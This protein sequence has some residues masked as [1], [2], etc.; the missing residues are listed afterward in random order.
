MFHLVQ[1]VELV[2]V[3]AL[4]CIQRPVCVCVCW[5]LVIML[6]AWTGCRPGQCEVTVSCNTV[7]KKLGGL[8]IKSATGNVAVT[9]Q[10]EII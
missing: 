7:T 5:N 9:T 4:A 1:I 3:C 10:S 2:P 6:N 8:H